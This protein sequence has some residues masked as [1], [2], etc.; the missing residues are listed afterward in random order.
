M[1]IYIYIYIH[2]AEICCDVTDTGMM[3]SIRGIPN[4]PQVSGIY[5]ARPCNTMVSQKE[6]K[7]NNTTVPYYRTATALFS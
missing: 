2:M 3:I 6:T 7:Q 1:C 4:C 5:H